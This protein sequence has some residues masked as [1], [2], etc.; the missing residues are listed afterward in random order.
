MNSQ[1]GALR[2]AFAFHGTNVA[3]D[4]ATVEKNDKAAMALSPEEWK[5]QLNLHRSGESLDGV[6]IP[7]GVRDEGAC[8]MDVLLQQDAIA[9]SQPYENLIKRIAVASYLAG[10]NASQGAR[11][12]Y[13]A[14][15]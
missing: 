7:F 8:V 4:I 13:L 3:A 11:D 15:K 5:R 14:K 10:L 1:T 2:I 6:E 12:A 9:H